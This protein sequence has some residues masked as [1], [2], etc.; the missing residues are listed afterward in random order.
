[1]RALAL[2]VCAAT[3]PVA[4][5]ASF[6]CRFK[7]ECLAFGPG[8]NGGTC[9]APQRNDLFTFPIGRPGKIQ[10]YH[11]GTKRI[12]T[13]EYEGKTTIHRMFP[14]SGEADTLT[15]TADGAAIWSKNT[16]NNGRPFGSVSIGTCRK[17]R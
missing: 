16:F 5:S 15:V 8:A 7:V 12:W 10:S 3:L 9:G 1:M 13:N 6:E 11:N 2:A 17:A 4:A 14:E